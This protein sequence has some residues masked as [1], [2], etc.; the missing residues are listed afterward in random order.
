MKKQKI[1]NFAMCLAAGACFYTGELAAWERSAEKS[2]KKESKS[3]K[4]S[5]AECKKQQE[6]CMNSVVESD[7]AS[8]ERS[9][10]PYAKS[11]F[12]SFTPERKKQALDMADGSKMTPDEVVA[13]VA[14]D[15]YCPNKK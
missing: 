15:C 1:L 5:S 6:D 10:A 4:K 9:L 14:G 2:C 8:F 11:I 13:K 7:N 3:C 12:V